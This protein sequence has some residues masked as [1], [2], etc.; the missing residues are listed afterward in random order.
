[1]MKKSI[2]A[3][4]AMAAVVECDPMAANDPEGNA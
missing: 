4:L 1:M 2:E 3:R